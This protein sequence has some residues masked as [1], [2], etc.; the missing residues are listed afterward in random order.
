[1]IRGKGSNMFKKNEKRKKE[2]AV[3]KEYTP[4]E[5][6]A[7]KKKL[8]KRIIGDTIFKVVFIVAIFVAAFMFVFGIATVET[9]DMYPAVRQGDVAIY[10]R[11]GE[12]MNNDVVLYE[13]GDKT[14]IGRIQATDGAEINKTEGNKL[15]IDGNIQPVQERSGLY[16]E[17]EVS[18]YDMLE[19]PSVVP[20]GAYLVLGDKRSD[21]IDSRSLG[22]IEKTNIKGKVFTIIRRRGL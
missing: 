22:Y 2:K 20:Q 7:R 6:I 8:L 9:D 10:F 5:T 13:A 17:T 19:Y 4:E 12:L 11:L 16:Y 14:R 15:S 21:A 18:K 1:M 3:N